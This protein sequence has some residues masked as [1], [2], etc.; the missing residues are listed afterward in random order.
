M[1]YRLLLLASVDTYCGDS[2]LVELLYFAD[3]M[4]D[5]VFIKKFCFC[6]V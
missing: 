4:A 1:E 2:R 5:A 6:H 3:K